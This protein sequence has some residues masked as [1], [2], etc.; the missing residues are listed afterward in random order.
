MAIKY[1][2]GSE[3]NWTQMTL[4]DIRTYG[5]STLQYDTIGQISI[6]PTVKNY[7]RTL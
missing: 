7:E 4:N 6:N 1:L 2:V 3:Q 5:V